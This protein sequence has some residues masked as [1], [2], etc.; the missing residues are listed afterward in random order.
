MSEPI[1]AIENLHVQFET[2][3]GTIHAVNGLSFELY[4]GEMLGLVRE[5]GCGKSVTGLAATSGMA[6]GC[7][8]SSASAG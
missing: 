4:P 1:L 6:A 5:S 8:H 3:A 7:P 2:Y